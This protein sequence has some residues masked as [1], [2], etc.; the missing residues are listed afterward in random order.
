MSTSGLPRGSLVA[1]SVE[2]WGPF[3]LLRINA[4]YNDDCICAEPA[5][6]SSDSRETAYFD[7]VSLIREAIEGAKPREEERERGRDPHDHF[8]HEP[9]RLRNNFA[10]RARESHTERKILEIY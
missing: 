4:R 3:G 10:K 6:S 7:F 1:I 2:S 8:W 5:R 9:R